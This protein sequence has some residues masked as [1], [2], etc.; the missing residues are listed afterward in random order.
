LLAEHL[1]GDFPEDFLFDPQDNLFH[2]GHIGLAVGPLLR[3]ALPEATGDLIQLAFA[4]GSH[5]FTPNAAG[6]SAWFPLHQK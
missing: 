5:R 4:V 2:A 3:Q 6:R 1:L